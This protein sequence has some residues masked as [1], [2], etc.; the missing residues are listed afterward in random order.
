MFVYQSLTRAFFIF[1]I[2]VHLS[3]SMHASSHQRRGKA[4]ERSSS[5]SSAASLEGSDLPS[6][7]SHIEGRKIRLEREYL[8][9]KAKR[10]KHKEEQSFA[11]KLKTMLPW[12]GSTIK[13]GQETQKAPVNN[14]RGKGKQSEHFDLLSSG[15][16]SIYVSAPQSPT[17]SVN[18]E[19]HQY[20]AMQAPIYSRHYG[21]PPRSFDYGRPSQK[22]TS[23]S[24]SVSSSRFGDDYKRFV[25]QMEKY[26]VKYGNNVAKWEK[27]TRGLTFVPNYDT[28]MRWYFEEG[29]EVGTGQPSR[30]LKDGFLEYRSN[31]F[32]KEGYYHFRTYMDDM[33][34]IGQPLESWVQ[35]TV[36][37]L[38][39]EFRPH[40]D[41]YLKRY[42]RDRKNEH[43]GYQEAYSEYLLTY[44]DQLGRNATRKSRRQSNIRTA[45]SAGQDI[46]SP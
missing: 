2:L 32:R 5:S 13:E 34:D 31:F 37:K 14:M 12:S 42:W 1:G 10:E 40:F 3:A 17:D 28:Y 18:S 6:H 8:E 36:T 43:R 41:E 44:K 21:S 19:Y 33:Y 25:E 4:L 16:N 24:Q 38:P 35:D 27:Q 45:S 46:G 29:K 9:K 22:P 39:E 23:S 26:R 7:G 20:P 11:H 15:S 30:Q